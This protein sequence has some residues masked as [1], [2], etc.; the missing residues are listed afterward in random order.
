MSSANRFIKLSDQRGFSLITAI[1]ACVIL[2]ALAILVLTLSTGDLRTSGRTAGEKKALSAAETGI[3]RLI[4]DFQNFDATNPVSF[5]NTYPR[6]NQQVDATN[7]P[8]SLYSVARPGNPVSGIEF[9]PMPGYAVGG[10][11]IWGQR[12]YAVTVEGENT[13]YNTTSAIEA[14][15]GYGPVPSTTMYD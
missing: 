3:H 4:E 8:A 13:N 15:L 10:G 7:D 12:H 2:F 5:M 9:L 14:G 6:N 11:K 1:L